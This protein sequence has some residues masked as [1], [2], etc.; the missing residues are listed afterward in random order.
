MI[1]I[2]RVVV[3]G[4]S[5]GVGKTTIATG[6]MAALRARGR[7]VAG[8]KIGPDFIDPSY[9][10][11]ATGRPPRNL[12]VF[13]S[14]EERIAPLFAAGAAGA[15]VAIV[16]G[17]MGL[18]DGVSG[19]GEL[20]STAQVARLLDAP[21]VLV[22]DAWGAA[23]S[24]A[25]TVLGFATFDPHVRIAGVV[26]NR[27]GSDRHRQLL[28]DALDQIG[29]P[30]LGAVTRDESLH[31][32]SRH[33]GLVPAAERAGDARATIDG[34][35]AT[36]AAAVDL[37]AVERVAA[38]APMLAARPW[39]APHFAGSVPIAVAQG[40]AFTFAYTEHLELLTAAGADVLPFD[41]AVDETLPDGARGVYLGGGF[42]E[43]YAPALAANSRL[44]A[45][46]ANF[47]ASGRPIVA[48]C[49]GLLYLARR[50]D[51]HEMCGVLDV[52]AEMTGR[53]TLGYREA[54]AA[55]DS[56]GWRQGE[57]V[58]AHEFH[59]TTVLPAA[60]SKP[61]WQ[62]PG[63]EEGFVDGNVH[64]SYLHSHWS[65]TPQVARRLVEAAA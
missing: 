13:L 29:T 54:R 36:M 48:E 49:G 15:D 17:V 19:R 56:V 12:D 8:F 28:V 52:D 4:T 46:I 24:V 27:V 22:V 23:R 44:R 5:S 57:T 37:D 50:L 60:G 11:V 9:H 18:F 21:V 33:L 65:G 10:A 39:S 41:P 20:A 1:R 35:A 59:R 30:L 47:A 40:T 38:D 31:T 45:E 64:A 53:L 34:L 55:V 63:S 14:G 2:P 26:A 62:L 58:R 43:V 7:R 3:A 61:A 51:G 25:A 6:L 16:E 42:P 32:P